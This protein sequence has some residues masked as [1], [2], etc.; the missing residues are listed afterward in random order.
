M[1]FGPF[2]QFLWQKN[3]FLENPAVSCTTSYGFLESSQNSEK[4]NNTIPRKR[5]DRWK[6]GRTEVQKDG[7][8]LCHWTLL[9]DARGPK[10]HRCV[11]IDES[12]LS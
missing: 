10:I 11:N 4:T 1:V 2:S 9:A 12:L 7:Q 8:T 3:F 5:P 6:D